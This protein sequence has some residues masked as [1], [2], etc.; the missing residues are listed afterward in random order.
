[1][2]SIQHTLRQTT[3]LAKFTIHYPMIRH[4]K[5]RFQMLRHKRLYE[6]IATD[7]YFSNEKSIEG[8]HCAQVFFAMTSKVLYVAGMK[9][10]SEFADVYLD[11]IRKYDIPSALRSDNANSEMSQRVKDIHRHLI[12]ADQWTELYSPWQ[13]ADELNG[14][15]YFKSHTQAIFDRAGTLYNLWFLEQDYLAHGYK[16]SSKNQI[17]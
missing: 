16:L 8:Y 3:Q 6:V 12:I 14:A 11:Y 10:E 13:N 1:M 2:P 17:N 4:L 7:A 5:S 9:T 15:K